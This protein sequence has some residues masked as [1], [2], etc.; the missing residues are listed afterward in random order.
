MFKKLIVIDFEQ[1]EKL[2]DKYWQLELF[3]VKNM[4]KMY[5]NFRRNVI[6]PN[7]YFID[8]LDEINIYKKLLKRLKYELDDKY[9]KIHKGTPLFWLGLSAFF[10]KKYDESI[11]YLDAAMAEDKK[12]HTKWTNVKNKYGPLWLFS[13]AAMFFRLDVKYIKKYTDYDVQELKDLLEI[14]LK[15]FNKIKTA[16]D[17]SIEDFNSKFVEEILTKS[18]N[19]SVITTLYS[20]IFEKN[21]IVE[22][23]ELRG[24]NGGTIEPM[25]LHLLKGAMILETLMKE[26]HNNEGSTLGAILSSTS[27]QNRYNY[28]SQNCQAQSLEQIINYLNGNDNDSVETAFH[29]TCRLRNTASHY[30]LWSDIFTS[31]N[32]IKLYKNI[33]NAI[34]YVIQKEYIS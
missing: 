21:D 3:D 15:S 18:K 25:I 22:M 4:D 33:L 17:V 16:D 10:L 11:F 30:L 28:T 23:L 2:A 19:T 6:L 5:A 12:N 7:R 31:E 32:Y 14:E 8:P 34:F 9:K 13:G 20:F 26:H 29:V 27:I 1:F 24:Q